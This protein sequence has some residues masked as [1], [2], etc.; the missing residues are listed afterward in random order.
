MSSTVHYIVLNGSYK[1]T[2]NRALEGKQIN[3][4]SESFLCT[5]TLFPFRK[6]H[7]KV[8]PA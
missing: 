7:H 3:K 1:K 4:H 6:L 2:S 8:K 5:V